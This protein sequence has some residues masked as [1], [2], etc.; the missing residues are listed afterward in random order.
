MRLLLNAS[1]ALILSFFILSQTCLATTF[2]SENKAVLDAISQQNNKSI[3]EYGQ[4][5]DIN[6][7][8]A[9][10]DMYMHILSMQLGQ[11]DEII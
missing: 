4:L 1:K 10:P 9:N 3:Y 7:S 5:D 6:L 2:E 11:K 8:S